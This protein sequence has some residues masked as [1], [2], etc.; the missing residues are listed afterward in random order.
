M[1]GVKHVTLTL[2]NVALTFLCWSAIEANTGTRVQLCGAEGDVS[3]LRAESRR[4]TRSLGQDHW[5][6][7]LYTIPYSSVDS[8]AW[9]EE[10]RRC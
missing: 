5:A 7:T 4:V 3:H 10:H 8:I 6:F 9:R 2:V 1:A